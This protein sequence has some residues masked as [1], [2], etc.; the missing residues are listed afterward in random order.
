MMDVIFFQ[1]ADIKLSFKE[2]ALIFI[3]SSFCYRDLEEDPLFTDLSPD[4]IL[5]NQEWLSASPPTT[6]DHPKT[7]GKTEVHKIVNRCVKLL[8]VCS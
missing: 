4:T 8:N 6:P 3:L 5:S 7:D 2:K 1:I